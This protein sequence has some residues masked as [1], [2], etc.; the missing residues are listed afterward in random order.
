MTALR[1]ELEPLPARLKRLPVDDRGYPVPWFVAWVDGKPEFRA[2]DAE[3]WRRAVRDRLCWVCG[4]PLGVHLTFVLG[5]MCGIT[6]T[7]AEPPAHLECARW[8]A[9]NCPFLTR[10]EMVRRQDA[11]DALHETSAGVPLDRNPGVTLLWSTGGYSVFFDPRRR[12]L[13]RVGPPEALEFYARGRLATAQEIEASVESGLPALLDVA[14]RE[15]GGALKDLLEKVRVFRSL[16]P[17]PA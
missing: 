8:S 1:P 15:G 5:P 6:R 17:G 3:K 4:V 13:L 10:P 2:A 12:P 14:Q 16:C 9:R 11:K 7:T